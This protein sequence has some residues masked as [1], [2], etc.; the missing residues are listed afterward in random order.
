MT[1][2]C[3]TFILF[4]LLTLL[5]YLVQWWNGQNSETLGDQSGGNRAL[6]AANLISETS[7]MQ[8]A[9]GYEGNV[10]SVAVAERFD[11]GFSSGFG[12][13]SY[14]GFGRGSS[15]R[16]GRGYRNRHYSRPGYPSVNNYWPYYSTGYYTYPVY[17][18]QYWLGYGTYDRCHDYAI[19]KCHDTIFPERCYANYYD[20]C[21][22]EL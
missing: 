12:R 4:I 10:A 11:R 1:A 17:N 2:S 3:S 5:V 19:S 14:R 9:T 13:G 15:R 21:N 7:P 22:L 18:P 8:I 6:T 20:R 16:F